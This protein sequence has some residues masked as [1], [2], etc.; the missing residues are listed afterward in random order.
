MCAVES[1]LS[2]GLQFVHG[3]VEQV[4]TLLQRAQERVFLFLYYLSYKF[5]LGFQ[6]GISLTHFTDKHREELVYERLFLVEERIGIAHGTAQ[7]AADY[8]SSLGIAGQLAV[9]NGECHGT[10]MVGH[11][12]H[13]HVYVLFLAVLLARKA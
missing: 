9:G 11:N 3:G 12:A 7:Y 5:A 13:S 6:L 2:G 8:I 4:D 10:K 1:V